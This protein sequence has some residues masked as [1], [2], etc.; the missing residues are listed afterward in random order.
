MMKANMIY[1]SIQN[2]KSDHLMS[3]DA[4]LGIEIGI[5]FIKYR[6]IKFTTVY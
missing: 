4:R 2:I 3:M 5:P 1:F 6:N